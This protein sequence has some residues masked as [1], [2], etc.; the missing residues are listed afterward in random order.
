VAKR[1]RTEPDGEPAVR[2]AVNDDDC[3]LWLRANG[4]A[5]F[6]EIPEVLMAR[7]KAQ[8]KG[9]RRNWWQM[10]AGKIDGTPRSA[11]GIDFPVLRAARRRQGLPD[12]PDAI[13]RNEDE[14]APA[15]RVTPRWP[16]NRRRRTRR[17]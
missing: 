8:N 12:V 4:Y 7:W 17:D 14:Q 2:R 3:R 15:I 16:R 13:C 6:A 1:K 10:F 11:D 5:D 9:T